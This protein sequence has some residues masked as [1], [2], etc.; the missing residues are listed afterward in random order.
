MKTN[1][2]KTRELNALLNRQYQSEAGKNF[3]PLD[4]CWHLDPINSRKLLLPSALIAVP[5][6]LHAY[7]RLAL[8]RFAISRKADTV[9]NVVESITRVANR[10]GDSF[11]ILDERDFL[12]AKAKA[13]KER[14]YQL[15]IIRG[16]LRFWHQSGLYGISDEF[17]EAIDQLT[18]KGNE[19]GQAV[20]SHDPLEG[21]YTQLEMEAII[22]GLNNAFMENR[23]SI[24]TWVLVKLY[25]ERGLRRSQVTQLVF[26]DFS[27]KSGGFFI[28]QPRSKQREVGFRESFS[29]FPISEDL[30][31]AL[32][33]LKAE[34]IQILDQLT[35]KE[36]ANSVSCLPL[37]PKYPLLIEYVKKDISID[38]SCF[39]PR[40]HL[41]GLLKR[42]ETAI[43][44]I[45]ERTGERIHFRAPLKIHFPK[46]LT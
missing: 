8:A 31:K 23:I 15:S 36:F 46:G 2:L 10:H 35:I 25:A 32:Q 42:A 24:E 19:K 21:P 44:A 41:N 40:E 20:L 3:R 13:G 16:F 34:R 22:D 11:N 29:Q 12:S 27:K 28:N 38:A 7:F 30:F 5:E 1:K 4:D 17:I 14:E 39:E 37:F 18:F 26:E 6:E 43:N 33:L 45:S 9:C